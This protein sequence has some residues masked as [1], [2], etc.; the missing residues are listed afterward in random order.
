MSTPKHQLADILTKVNFTRGT[1]EERIVGKSK[2]TLNLVSYSA[3]SS[4][5]APSS[6]ASNRPGVL[7]ARFESHSQAGNLPLDVQIRVTP[8]RVLQCGKEMQKRTTVRGNSLLQE[9]T[10]I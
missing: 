3:A 2:P 4:S 8:P 6:S 9:R 5:T 1:R 7:R 10:R